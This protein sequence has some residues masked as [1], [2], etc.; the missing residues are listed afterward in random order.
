MEPIIEARK[1]PQ[2]EQCIAFV[3]R[4]MLRRHFHQIWTENF[5]CLQSAHPHRPIIFFANHSNWWDGLIAFHLSYDLLKLDAYLMM[6]ARQ[7]RK[8]YFFKMI[9]AFSVDRESAI[10]A[11]RSLQY[12]EKLL[13]TESNKQRALWIFPQGE[14]LPND[15]RP[16]TFLRGLAWL[17]ER[18]PQAQLIAV[19]FRYE[20]L[21]EQRPEV[22]LS[23]Q[24]PITIN[25]QERRDSRA[26]T[27]D[28]QARLTDQLDRL[29]DQV[30]Y[31]RLAGFTPI[32]PGSTSLNIMY[33]RA[34]KLLKRSE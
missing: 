4:V 20:F 26:L 34:L 14:M 32:L 18:V 6:M 9:G 28:L 30:V 13:K 29:K 3:N 8:Y 15:I 10:S 17:V 7:L 5:A 23:F 31:Q 33:E 11:Y 27:A 22:F 19:T 12:A 21:N 16:L 1:Q 24:G 25:E 2:A